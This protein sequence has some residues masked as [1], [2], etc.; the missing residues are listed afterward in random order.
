MLAIERPK[1]ILDYRSL[2]V[3][4]GTTYCSFRL[5]KLGIYGMNIAPS[6]PLCLE[7]L[8]ADLAVS[9]CKNGFFQFARL[10]FFPDSSLPLVPRCLCHSYGFSKITRDLKSLC[11]I[12]IS[13]PW[14]TIQ[15][16]ILRFHEH[17]S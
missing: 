2:T 17:P 11:V 5:Y 1:L 12:D 16:W 6:C 9:P 4:A 13:P 10:I 3:H 8:R 14:Q 15:T 7:D